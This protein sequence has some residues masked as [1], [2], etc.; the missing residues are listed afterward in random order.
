MTTK[1]VPQK[2]LKEMWYKEE[3]ESLNNESIEKN[4]A[5]GGN[6]IKKRDL[7]RIHHG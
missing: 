3:E 5:H 7:G 6:W 2:M 4:K 1:T